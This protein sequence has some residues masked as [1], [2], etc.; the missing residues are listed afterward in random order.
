MVSFTVTMAEQ[1]KK[2]EWLPEHRGGCPGEGHVG[3]VGGRHSQEGPH[4][5]RVW[6]WET[7]V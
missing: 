2:K 1:S 4:D 6:P 7:A 3:I 5:C